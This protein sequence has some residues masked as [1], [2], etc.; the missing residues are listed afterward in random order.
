MKKFQISPVSQEKISQLQQKI[1]DKTKPLGALGQLEYLALKIGCIQNTLSPTLSK[2]TIVVF[3]GDHGI[4][5]E[6]VSLYP[7]SVTYQMV[8]NFLAGGAAINVFA[9]QHNINLH[10]VDAGVNHEF[11]SHPQL[12]NYKIAPGTK[13]FLKKP[14]MTKQQCEQAIGQGATLVKDIH[15]AGCNVISFGEMGIGNTSSASMLAHFL[16]HIPLEDCVGKGTGLDKSGVTHKL[17]I[18]QQAIAK[19][20]MDGNVLKTLSTFGGFEIAMMAGA[21]LQ[22][23][24]LKM[25]IL[26]DG[27]IATSA[28]LVAVKL[29]PAILDY[30]IFS[31]QSQEKGHRLVL[32][33]LKAKSLLNLEMRLGEGSGAAVAFPII[34]SAVHFL[35]EMASF[36]SAGVSQAVD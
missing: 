18:L 29:Y 22:A 21:Y 25:L 11:E 12:L 35:N 27:F 3:A 1:N 10:I 8:L 2:L 17:T 34:Q 32:K 15:Q 19:H 33:Y 31:H 14:A 28:L 30:C 9:K 6:G 26:V 5:T 7:Q 24:E 36:E 13:N 20:P 23:T 16:A 4:A